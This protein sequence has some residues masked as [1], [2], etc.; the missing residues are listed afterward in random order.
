VLNTVGYTYL[1]GKI[2]LREA[3]LENTFEKV[4]KLLESDEFDKA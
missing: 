4:V 3:K 1:S 2:V